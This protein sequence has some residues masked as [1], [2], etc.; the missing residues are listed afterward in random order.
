MSDLLRPYTA[1]LAARFQLTLQYRAAALAGFATQLWWGAIK[2]MVYAAFYASAPAAAAAA[3]ISLSQ[4]ITYTWIAQGLLAMQPWSADPEIAQAVR[5]GGV[6][7]DRLRPMD[8]YGFW[9]ARSTAWLLARAAPRA[10]LMV[11]SA[12]VLLPLL[13]YPEW[14]WRP[15]AGVLA[16]L[17]FVASLLLSALLSG[18]FIMVLNVLVAATLNERGVNTLSIP[19]VIVLSGNMLPLALYPPALQPL[20]LLQPL[21]GIL[22]IP[23]RI[24]FGTMAGPE[25]LLGLGLQVFWTVVLVLVGRAG[26][27][28]VMRRLQVQ[29]G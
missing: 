4:A 25:V 24:Y 22:D 28:A 5:T 21:A 29:G 7:Y 17:F 3:P 20:L 26:L 10:T 14:S 1:A 27:S 13:G 15:P 18:A 2:V 6:G 11:L 19:V 12:G 23:C 9:Y 8:T 16:G